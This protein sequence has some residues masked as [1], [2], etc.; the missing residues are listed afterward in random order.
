MIH[1]ENGSLEQEVHTFG[2]S[3]VRRLNLKSKTVQ[4]GQVE[5]NYEVRLKENDSAF[6]NLLDA[7]DGVTQVALVSY[8][9]DYMG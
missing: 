3:Q 6:V 1:C 7:M 4:R 5:L 2:A 9:G 8:N